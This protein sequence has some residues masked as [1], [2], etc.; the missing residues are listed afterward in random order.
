MTKFIR[1]PIAFVLIFIL[2]LSVFWMTSYADDTPQDLPTEESSAI[3]DSV[4]QFLDAAIANGTDCIVKY[5]SDSVLSEGVYLEPGYDELTKQLYF[6][7]VVDLPDGYTI[8]D[9]ENTP[10]IDGIKI[11][12][13]FL[14][15]PRPYKVSLT[16]PAV[17]YTVL[18][19]IV[20]E[21]GIAGTVAK[22]QNGDASLLDL[23]DNPVMLMQVVYYILAAVSV[24]LG[25]VITARSRK[26]KAKT[27]N[28]IASKTEAAVAAAS[29]AAKQELVDS[30]TALI[31]EK[32][33]PMLEACV[34]SNKNVVKAIAVSNSKAKDAPITLLDILEDS[35]NLDVTELLNSL[36]LDAIA[37]IEAS[38]TERANT[39][40]MLKAISEPVLATPVEPVDITDEQTSIF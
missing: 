9:K 11:N 2:T 23:F 6:E 33:G 29:G 30:V 4:T 8:F 31:L 3:P 5:T 32:I 34:H 10:Y 19:K 35:S 38:E 16:D 25:A 12:E 7:I 24:I 21:D 17:S 1:K 40:N 39:L 37:K 27:S 15:I 20:Y 36:R 26:H 18:V 22:I 13:E 28:D 14:N